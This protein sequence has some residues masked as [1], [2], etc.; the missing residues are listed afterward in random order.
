MDKIYRIYMED[1][2]REIV[3]NLVAGKFESFTVQPTT[4]RSKELASLKYRV[5]ERQ[6]FRGYR[7]LPFRIR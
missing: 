7:K 3:I 5:A 1:L 2:D 4:M 6:L